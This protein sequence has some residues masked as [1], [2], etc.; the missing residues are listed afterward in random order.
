MSDITKVLTIMGF[1][2]QEQQPVTSVVGALQRV[3]SMKRR[4]PKENRNISPM[5]IEELM[6]F[7]DWYVE[8]KE[9]TKTKPEAIEEAF[10]EFV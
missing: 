5:A 3:L 2:K 6:L 10:T 1:S 7:K 4:A 9:L 8:W